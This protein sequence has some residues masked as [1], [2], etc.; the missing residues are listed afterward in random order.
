MF[1]FSV[2]CRGR[3]KSEPDLPLSAADPAARPTT[4]S[5]WAR[6]PDP[7]N[8]AVLG[9]ASLV[10]VS[11]GASHHPAPPAL[12]PPL[13]C[14]DLSLSVGGRAGGREAHVE[15]PENFPG[16]PCSLEPP[17]FPLLASPVRQPAALLTS[18]LVP[19]PRS[20]PLLKP[21]RLSWGELTGW[22]A[23][24]PCCLARPQ[25]GGCCHAFT[26]CSLRSLGSADHAV[27]HVLPLSSSP[28]APLTVA[29][30][31]ALHS[32]QHSVS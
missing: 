8:T 17:F 21:Q 23:A 13:P 3:Q 19:K 14:G 2:S 26:L 11:L 24:P 9:A 28:K 32:T 30:L 31:R 18:F 16:T 5:P 29:G 27:S 4:P 22:P 10:R 7:R 6:C 20:L 25:R 1:S 15:T 12:V